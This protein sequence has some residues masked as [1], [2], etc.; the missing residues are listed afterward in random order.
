MKNLFILFLV[1]S[2]SGSAQLVAAAST[3]SAGIGTQIKDDSKREKKKKRKKACCKT[4]AK[5][6][7]KNKPDCHKNSSSNSA[8]P[9]E[10]KAE[11]TPKE[12]E[13]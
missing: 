6:C 10:S 12:A 11:Q 3:L 5:S 1:I 2:L 9:E 7:D 8:K 4:D 13:K